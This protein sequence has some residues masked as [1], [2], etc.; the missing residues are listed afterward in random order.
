MGQVA[1]VMTGSGSIEDQMNALRQQMN[2]VLLVVDDHVEFGE[3]SNPEDPENSL[4]L[5]AGD[6]TAAGMHNGTVSNV[7]GSWVEIE[8]TSAGIT[9]AVCTHN[10]FM[11]PTYTVPVAGEPNCRWIHFALMHD[12][13]A[14]DGTSLFTVD[15]NFI[16]GT[17]DPEAIT[18]RMNLVLAGTNIT[19]DADHPV[20]VSLFFTKATRGV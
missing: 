13:T 19:V 18:L 1:R 3:P 14:A 10:L 6:M 4:G 12:G 15:I 8:L 5:R 16:G 11:D 9:D 20:L 2:E 17:V 7:Q